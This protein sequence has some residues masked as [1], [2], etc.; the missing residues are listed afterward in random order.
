VTRDPKLKT[1]GKRVLHTG[2]KI[3]TKSLTD[4][5]KV[6]AKKTH[7]TQTLLRIGPQ[8]KKS[9]V[10]KPADPPIRRRTCSHL[11][12]VWD[13]WGRSKRGG[14]VKKAPHR[15]NT[16]DENNKRMGG[17]NESKTR[18]PNRGSAVHSYWGV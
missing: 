8:M 3:I 1:L 6:I 5:D 18:G 11:P 4:L 10:G 12:K 13:Q 17:K 14:V 9:I 16:G 15:T 2:K 7:R